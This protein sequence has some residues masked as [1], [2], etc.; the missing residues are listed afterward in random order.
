MQGF[1]GDLPNTC[2]SP[3]YPAPTGASRLPAGKHE[4]ILT[5]LQTKVNKKIGQK[6]VFFGRHAA[7]ACRGERLD[8]HLLLS[9][10]TSHI[11]TGF[12]KLAWRA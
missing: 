5:E 3:L 4:S 6:G 8:R 2:G 11:L 9:G 7:I 1:V 10:K 12:H